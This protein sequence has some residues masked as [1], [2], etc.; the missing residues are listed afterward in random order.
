[1]LIK[2]IIKRT[3][4]ADVDF[5]ILIRALDHELWNELLEDQ[6]TYDQY[7][8]VPDLQTV[9]IAYYNAIPVACGCIKLFDSATAEIKRMFVDKA[10][11]GKGLSKLVLHE[12]ESWAKALGF[13]FCILETSIHFTVAIN[14]YKTSG[15]H[16]I[17]NYGPYEG[18][19]ESVC[20]KKQLL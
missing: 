15:Y 4:A 6:S 17:A 2:P 11:R 10:H 16:I 14:L 12:L 5:N 20:M 9:V 19:H 1:M 18:L 3:T 7:N 8:K 13:S